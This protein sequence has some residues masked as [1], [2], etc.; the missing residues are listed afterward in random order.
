MATV[1]QSSFYVAARDATAE[2]GK[3][4][5]GWVI[6]KRQRL[7]DERQGPWQLAIHSLQKRLRP[8]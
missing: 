3:R 6:G 4:M 5:A 7:S 1:A 8:Q 2:L